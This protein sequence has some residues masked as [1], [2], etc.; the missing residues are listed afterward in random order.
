MP[1]E[2]VS[3]VGTSYIW[4]GTDDFQVLLYF[5]TLVYKRFLDRRGTKN[6]G[7]RVMIAVIPYLD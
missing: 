3:H 6:Q 1:T 7:E 5:D 2:C 4:Y